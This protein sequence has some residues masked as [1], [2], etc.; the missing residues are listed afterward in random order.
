MLINF[1]KVKGKLSE[2]KLEERCNNFSEVSEN[3][4]EE[5]AMR[6]AMR[7]L[8]C[9]DKPCSLKGCPINQQIPEFIAKV[10][11]GEFEE[12]YKIIKQRSGNKISKRKKL[13]M[14]MLI[15]SLN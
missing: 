3:Y 14:I 7:C 2:T 15:V 10:S 8:K 12:A 6:E 13:I 11:V 1:S 9:R 5:R 4:T